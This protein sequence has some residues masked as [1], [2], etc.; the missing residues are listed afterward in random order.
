MATR[1]K[2][3]VNALKMRIN[4]FQTSNTSQIVKFYPE[5]EKIDSK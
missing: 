3:A 5:A 2:V 4:N 1:I